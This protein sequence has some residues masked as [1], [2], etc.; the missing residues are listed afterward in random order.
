MTLIDMTLDRQQAVATRRIMMVAWAMVLINIGIG[1]SVGS[2]PVVAALLALGFAVLGQASMRLA[3]GIAR[4]A[5]GQALIGQAIAMTAA[6]SGHPWQLD[7][8]M[9]FFALMAA[10]VALVDVRVLL[11]GAAT[12]VL[13]HL[14]LSVVLPALIYPSAE[15]IPNVARTLFHGAI[16]AVETVFLIATVRVR[17]AMDRA[18]TA[19]AEDLARASAEA[20][21]AQEE[22]EASKRKALEDKRAAEAAMEQAT[23]AQ[24][25]AEQEHARAAEAEM[26]RREAERREAENRAATEAAQNEVMA[27]LRDRLQRLADGNLSATISTAFSDAYEDLRE[28]FNSAVVKLR[29]ALGQA[30]D[31]SGDI[32]REAGDISSAADD[33][34]RRTEH[35][36][37]TLEETAAA[38]EQL[39]ASVRSAASVAGEAADAVGAA[40]ETARHG[41]DVVGRAI[42]AMGEIESS[43][44]KI[45]R[46]TS[47]IDD[48][49]FQ[50]NLLAVNAG[51]EAARAGDAGRGFAVVASEVR[52]LAQRSSDAAREISELINASGGHVRE[53][54]SLVNE[55]GAA[56]TE[57]MGSVEEISGFVAQIATSAKEQ[58]DVF[59]EING[60]VSQLDRVTQQNAAMF[61]QTTAAS[62]SLT[63]LATDLRAVMDRFVIDSEAGAAPGFAS[64]RNTAA[65]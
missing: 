53:G 50:T 37:A 40:T 52:G 39:T 18:Q 62:H 45:A 8:H 15:L 29:A 1:F 56:L 46:I 28:D 25:Q 30:V 27:T 57:I 26:A 43:S 14:V 9:A 51:V 7:S 11:F 49:A 13:H 38:V 65:A 47:V 16:V 61:E 34:A 32:Q 22:A 41:G 3:P 6:F 63:V 12:I 2:L 21:A 23:S 36:A 44:E 17:L 55:S 54:V 58:A 24:A 19:R 59:S 10:L 5:A 64:R 33:L 48:I 4:I 31:A 35:Q 42:T 20:R 60:S